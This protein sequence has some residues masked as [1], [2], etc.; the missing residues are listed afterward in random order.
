MA[1]LPDSVEGR[2]CSNPQASLRRDSAY[3]TDCQIAAITLPRLYAGAMLRHRPIYRV[4]RERITTCESGSCAFQVVRTRRQKDLY[5]QAIR[6]QLLRNDG[7]DGMNSVAI[8]SGRFSEG[9]WFSLAPKDL[10]YRFVPSVFH[11]GA[12]REL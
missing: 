2:A 12:S 8:P 9:V 5:Y 11:L 7:V 3:T 1:P 6:K 4:S 10:Y